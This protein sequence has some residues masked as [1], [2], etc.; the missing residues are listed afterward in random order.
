[1]KHILL[2]STALALGFAGSAAAAETAVPVAPFTWTGCY[3]GANAGAA[4]LNP[5]WPR[6]SS[7]DAGRSGGAALLPGGFDSVS[8]SRGDDFNFNAIGGVAG[9]QVGC[10]WQTRMLVLGFEGEGY[11][12]S[13]KQNTGNANIPLPDNFTGFTNNWQ[14]RNKSDADI[15]MRFGFAIDRALLFGKVGYA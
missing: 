3:V 14:V 2:I 15:A 4:S 12:S 1:M 11:W 5:A 8:F 10:N 9:G 7:F 6:T 13:L